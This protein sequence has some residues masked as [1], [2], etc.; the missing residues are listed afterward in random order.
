[1]TALSIAGDGSLTQIGDGSGGSGCVEN[2]P[3]ADDCADG[4]AL[5]GPFSI[6][7]SSSND[8]IYVAGCSDASVVALGRDPATGRLSPVSGASGCFDATAPTAARP[9]PTSAAA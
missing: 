6:N 7:A 9:T 1:M 5:G 4:R 2:V 8:T 3:S